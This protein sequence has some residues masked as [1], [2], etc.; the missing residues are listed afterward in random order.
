MNRASL[1]LRKNRLS[2]LFTRSSLTSTTALLTYLALADFVAHMLF[3]GNY[4]YFRDELYYIVSGTQ[5]L[6]LGYVDFPPLVAYIAAFLNVVSGD[7]LISIHVVSALV[8]ALLV[9]V[10]GMIA[11]ELGGGRRAQLLAAASTLVTLAFLAVGSE[12]SPVVFDELWWSLLAYLTIRLVKRREPKIWIPIGV[13]V[14]IGLLTKLTM[15][16]F[17]GA[18]LISFL[19]IPSSRKYVQS[20][21]GRGRRL[22]GVCLHLANDLLESR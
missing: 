19:A 10:A 8:G 4:G 14:G 15:L 3:A 21:M 13:V 20:K 2:D 9:F 16:F 12:F 11:R 17:V 7:S 1:S 18:L 6:S 22:A 5:H